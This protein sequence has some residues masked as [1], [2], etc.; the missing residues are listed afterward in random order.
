MHLHGKW[1]ENLLMMKNYNDD[2]QKN[3]N[4]IN[5][6]VSQE[7]GIRLQKYSNQYL[8]NDFDAELAFNDIYHIQQKHIDFWVNMDESKLMRRKKSTFDGD[9]NDND[10]G[11][12]IKE[13]VDRYQDI[14]QF[15]TD[16]NETRAE[17]CGEFVCGLMGSNDIEE[18]EKGKN[19]KAKMKHPT[20]L[21]IENGKGSKNNMKRIDS[22]DINELCINLH[23]N[24]FHGY[25][26]FHALKQYQVKASK[27]NPDRLRKQEAAIRADLQNKLRQI[28]LK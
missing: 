14:R 23:K 21:P 20:M 13:L 6:D 1:T 12:D 11:D 27:I 7:K 24:M 16:M 19:N 28:M 10:D 3:E 15:C 9:S 25:S 5:D 22:N 8:G 17:F 4:E 18:I 26:L 2:D